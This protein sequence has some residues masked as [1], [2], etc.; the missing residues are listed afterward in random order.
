MIRKDVH[1]SA[2]ALLSSWKVLFLM[3]SSVLAAKRSNAQQFRTYDS[4]RLFPFLKLQFSRLYRHEAP[5]YRQAVF[6]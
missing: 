5:L 1:R 4:N 3:T 6:Y 2:T